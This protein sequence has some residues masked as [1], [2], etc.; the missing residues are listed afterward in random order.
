MEG[1][2]EM[3]TGR[4][5]HGRGGQKDGPSDGRKERGTGRQRRDGG[6]MT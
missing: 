4:D 2:V 5:P 3:N 6:C 1:G